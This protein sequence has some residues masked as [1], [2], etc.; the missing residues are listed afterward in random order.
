MAKK[1]HHIYLSSLFAPQNIPP[2]FPN[3]TCCLM[4]FCSQTEVISTENEDY[5]IEESELET[6]TFPEK[7]GELQMTRKKS[8]AKFNPYYTSYLTSH[9]VS[10]STKHK[11]ISTTS[12]KN[13]QSRPRKVVKKRVRVRGNE[14]FKLWLL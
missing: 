14:N 5:E 4:E 12:Q 6:T 2:A 9:K 7:T 11:Q 1:S 13:R 8:R 3:S 10:T